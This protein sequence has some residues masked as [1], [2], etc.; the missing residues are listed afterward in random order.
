MKVDR[1]TLNCIKSQQNEGRVLALAG[2]RLTATCAEGGTLSLLSALI[3]AINVWVSSTITFTSVFY[4]I[5]YKVC[6]ML[7]KNCSFSSLY[8][9]DERKVL[10]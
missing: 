4:V 7:Y 1:S 3:L 2:G 9:L 6:D 10:T 5:S 8:L